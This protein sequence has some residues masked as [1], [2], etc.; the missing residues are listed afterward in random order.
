MSSYK[1]LYDRLCE[2]EFDCVPTGFQ[3]TS[4]V[5]DI[6][7]ER[8][9]SLCDDNILCSEVCDSGDNQPEWK[10]RLRTAQQVLK[11]KPG[12]RVK[13]LSSG[14]FY[15]PRDVEIEPV[16]RDQSFEVGKKYN[17]WELHDVF[18]GQRYRGIATPA[19]DPFVFIF[20][21]KSGEDYGYEDDFLADDTFIYTGEGA[22]GD[23]SMTD[24]NKAIRNHRDEGEEIYLF[25]DTEY[26]WIVTYVGEFEYIDHQWDTL[27]DKQQEKRDA[28]RFQ[29]RPVGGTHIEIEDGSPTSL[30]KGDLFEKAK[31]SSP[32]K[33]AGT[34]RNS[35]SSASS[36]RSYPRSEVVKK[37]ALKEA[38]GICQGC[39]EEAPF[40]D[41]SGMPFLEVHHLH[42]RSDGG[43]DDPE[44]V[45]AICPNCHR[46]VH[47][48][49]KGNEYN[50]QL[51]EVAETRN[52]RYRRE[53]QKL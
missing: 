26:P 30:S 3:E 9:P 46:R 14:W 11:K 5:Y 45:L 47:H 21:G 33:S 29:L 43:P 32:T 23:M 18:G 41:E 50:R 27:R 17:R 35:P 44:N 20:T 2:A 31:Q 52:K 34:P 40:I 28:I 7:N 19:E 42:R 15:N 49:E 4:D 53:N 6:V 16:D 8:Y 36:G 1:E 10:H 12:S 13:K 38:D 39:G 48:G 51:I 25:E 24:G 37:F 22:E